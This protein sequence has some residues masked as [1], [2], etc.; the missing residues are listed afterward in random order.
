MSEY[1]DIQAEGTDDPEVVWIT[2][3]VQLASGT[4]VEIY[5]SPEEGDDGSALAQALFEIPGLAGLRLDGTEMFIRR[6]PGVEWPALIADVSDAL[7][8]FF[9]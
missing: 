9:L 1:V 3:N 8:D 2:T 6:E 5:E 7:R 4:E